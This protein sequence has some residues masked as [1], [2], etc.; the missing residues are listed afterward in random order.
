M[1][2]VTH[3]CA[4]LVA[5]ALSGPA[6]AATETRNVTDFDEVVFAVPGEVSI[7]TGPT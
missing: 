6:Q 2:W 3:G 1:S 4:A 5:T 7:D